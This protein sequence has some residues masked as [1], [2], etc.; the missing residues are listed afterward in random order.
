M[1]L[2]STPRRPGLGT[3]GKPLKVRTNFFPILSLPGQNLH[4]YDVTITPEASPRINRRLFTLWE[5]LNRN[6]ILK[7]TRPVFDGKKSIYSSRLLPL[8]DDVAVFTLEI[9]DNGDNGISTAKSL[10]RSPRLFRVTIKK[11]AE[12]SMHKLNM[13][14]DGRLREAPTDA[15]TALDIL[16]R[17][18]PSM[19][20][21][22]VGRCFY[23]PE[24]SSLIANGAELWQGFHQSVQ[25]TSN[26]MLL[27]LDVSATAFLESGPVIDVVVRI[28]GKTRADEIRQPLNDRDRSRIEK[29]LK[30][31]KIVTTHRGTS[32][33]RWKIA[34]LTSTP[35][36][37]TVFPKGG[38]KPRDDTVTNYFK[39]RYNI[40]LFHDIFPCLIVGDPSKHIYLPMEVCQV[41]PGQRVLRKLNER[42]TSDMIR[43]T[44]QPPHVRS[45]KVSNGFNLLF[46]EDNKYLQDF[47]VSIGQE[48]ATVN[49]RLLPTPVLS[50]HPTSRESNIAPR[51]GSWN[52]RD[53]K[54]AQGAVLNSW[55]V[56]VFG[57]EKE[58]T[59]ASVQKFLRELIVTCRDTGV[60][61][62]QMQPPIRHANP[63][64][65]IAAILKAAYMDAGNASNH[66][67]QLILVILPN[68]NVPLYA[69]IKRIADTDVGI[70]TQCM[71]SKHVF[72][73]KKQY[74]ANICLKINVKLG[75][76]NCFLGGSQLSF[77]S[78]EPTI[79][80][81]ADITHPAPGEY[82]KPSI[83][84]IVGSLDARCSRY[85]AAIRIQKGRHEVIA[86][87]S[88]AVVE[89]LRTFYQFSGS[90]PKRILFYRDGV[91]ESQYTEVAR[92]EVAAIR[93]ACA[94]LEEGYQPT[95]TFV[96]IHK[97]HHARFFPL[98]REDSDKSGNVL[99]GTVVETGITHPAEFDFYLASHPGL[100][101]TS[102]PTHYHVLHD[103]NTFTADGLQELTYRLC[104]LYCR[105]T[106]A[107]SVCPPAYYAHLVAARARF[108]FMGESWSDVAQERGFGHTGFAGDLGIPNVVTLETLSANHGQVK[109]D[110]AKSM[111]YM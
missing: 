25:P 39:E 65:N 81:G 49:A 11:V 94:M 18:R 109:P 13:F 3:A 38:D 97:R 87:L 88:G 69:E 27:N 100:Q 16:F 103:E 96:I 73:A 15:V 7:N 68:T 74:C 104:Y 40:T 91:S 79:I 29:A 93:K 32:K 59:V 28:L 111:Y 57:S 19:L 37:K 30:G 86:D 33:R 70:A 44:C 22:T 9:P 8:K 51:E 67:P 2:V 89:L 35:A 4:H 58:I 83:A 1:D 36:S 85:A 24:G 23:T 66:K 71:Q 5:D 12:I 105:A 20:Y 10:T 14:L 31:V 47:N 52:L 64:G 26:R 84:A 42:Q 60:D 61:I 80:F 110:L 101:G 99:P 63:L 41:V 56:V 92:V 78:E 82:N 17:H 72:A 45:N 50:Y 76:M 107:V 95:L 90:K 102:K 46:S 34:K 55:S 21:T 98:R 62:R 75:G 53:K 6:G 108:H 77:V 106:R 48:M 54:V 43:F